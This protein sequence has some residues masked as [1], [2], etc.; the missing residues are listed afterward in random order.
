[1]KQLMSILLPLYFVHL[2]F[3]FAVLTWWFLSKK[4]Q[5]LRYFGWGT[6]GYSLGIAAWTLLVLIKPEDLKPLVLAGV[7]PF[8]LAHLAYAKSASIKTKNNSMIYLTLLLLVITFLARTFFYP[9][10][11]YFSDHGGFFFGLMT[12]PLVLYIATV[13]VSLL[14]AI[15]SMISEIKQASAKSLMGIGFTILYVNIVIQISAKSLTIL[16]INGVVASIVLLALWIKALS[17]KSNA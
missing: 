5:S 7:V 14:P 9:S 6:L 16:F 8:L 15:R 11:P 13:S 3:G 1:M 10:E 17:A 4:N 12:I 2:T